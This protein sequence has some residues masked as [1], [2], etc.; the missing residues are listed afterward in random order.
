MSKP[1]EFWITYGVVSGTIEIAAPPEQH[2]P[3]VNIH[4]REVV[5]IDWDKVFFGFDKDLFPMHFN[6]IKSRVEKQL[7]GEE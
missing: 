1:R 2:L 6:L 3:C 4:V 7:A 5:P